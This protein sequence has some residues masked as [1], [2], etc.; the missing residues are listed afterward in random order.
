MYTY[1]GRGAVVG[2]G[3][4]RPLGFY[5]V[6]RLGECYPTGTDEYGELCAYV[7][8]ST[9]TG[10]GEGGPETTGIPGTRNNSSGES[11]STSTSSTFIP[12]PDGTFLDTLTG[13]IL[14][15]K[16]GGIIGGTAK[17]KPPTTTNYA[18]YILIAA[19]VVGLMIMLKK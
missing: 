8:P 6:G 1:T 12:Q 14:N 13:L 5:G 19:G 17:P 10:S 18:N 15:P 9:Q 4:N 16:T 2:R 7:P 3:D 11:G